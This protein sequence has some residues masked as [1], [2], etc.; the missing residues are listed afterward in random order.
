MDEIVSLLHIN[1]QAKEKNF[2][3]VII[4]AAPTGET[5]RLLTIPDTFRWYAG[6]VSRLERG[7]VKA[8]APFAGR[9]LKAPAEVLEALTKL[10]QQTAELR[11]T[12]SDPEIASYRVVLFPEKMVIREAERAVSYLGLFN[13]PVDSVI[14][15]RVLPEMGDEGEFF[16]QR[17]AIQTKYL[18]MIQNNFSPLPLW[19][20]PY[21]ANEVV[22][23]E[24]LSQL[25]Q[26]CFG[27]SDPG[28]IFYRGILQEIEE[29]ENGR[30]LMRLP[31][32]FVKSSD[33]K[34]RKRGDEMFITIGNF[35][36]EMILPT[37]LAKMR[38][39]GGRL[40]DDMLEIEFLPIE[41]EAAVSQP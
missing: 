39:G 23:M 15:N 17:R 16:Q 21:Y 41:K 34:L 27:D 35:K 29:Q 14:V 6:H 4:D 28:E 19:Y 8:L 12:L 13:Y 30:Y 33:V 7:V 40:V 9:F 1:K 26:D 36:R 2:D 10:D 11:E 3:R 22:G 5:I 31:M 20:A 24:A 18:E 25:A 32:P 38:A 37:V